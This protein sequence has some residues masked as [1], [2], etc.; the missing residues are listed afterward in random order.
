ML[1]RREVVKKR[2]YI[3]NL[4]CAHCAA[5]LESELKRLDGVLDVSVDFVGQVISLQY[6][7]DETLKKVVAHVNAFEEVRVL[8]DEKVKEE[9][10]QSHIKE[11][12]QL[13]LS[14]G[15][16][17]VGILLERLLLQNGWQYIAYVLY[18]AVYVTVGFPVL[19]NTA[20]NIAKG[21][22]FDENFLMT[23]ASIG[24]MALGEI[25]EGIAVMWLYQLG[26][27]LQ[28]IAVGSS[29]KSL[30][31]LVKLKSE[32]A[33]VLVDGKQKIVQPEQLQVGDTVL[34]KA[35]ERVPADG[36]LLSESA[37]I[38]T[39]ALTG[40]SDILQKQ[41][42]EEILSGCINAG[43]VYEMKVVRPY[44]DSAV[45][46]ILSLVEE[47]SSQ[48]AKPERFISK[49]A[50]YY[51]PIVCILAV[52]IA[53][54]VPVISRLALGVWSEGIFARWIQT[55][56]TFLVI[57]CPCALIISVPLTYFSGIGACAKYGVLVK[58]AVNLDVLAKTKI[59]AFDKTGTLTKGNFTV[60]EI[61]PCADLSKSQ[62]VLLA[63]A[64]EKGSSHSIAKAFDE[65]VPSYRAESVKELSGKGMCAQVKGE[66]VLVGNARLLRE[67]C[68]EF[69]E[70][71]SEDT[72]VYVAKGGKLVGVIEIGDVVRQESKQVIS[73]LKTLAI[74]RTVML[75]GDNEK[76]AQKVANEI[77]M[78]E[79][80]AKLLPDEKLEEAEYLKNLGVLTYVG[81]GINDAPVMAASDC[82]VS[83]G[84][85]GSAAAVEASDIVLISD[86]LR[87]IVTCLKVAKKTA[88][89]VKQNIIF[90]IAMKTAFMA[91]GVAGVLP[92][93]LAVFADV[94]VMLLA[95]CNSLRV[96]KI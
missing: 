95:V 93:A 33:T 2:I 94:G 36:V 56:L 72:L 90:S 34:V 47:A 69:D 68:V 3:E 32:Q 43:G 19:K 67:Y 37:Q 42:G 45:S 48:K 44:Q 96:R 82:A 38:D 24:A 80:K 58:G 1:I 50:K 54:L 35:G 71:E 92:L 63:A 17:L 46:K 53:V 10:S 78:Y 7:S 18:T 91:L 21:K 84:K 6:A 73:Q 66:Q 4:D 52:L 15:M 61:Y 85:L 89:I 23:V 27:L 81:D 14:L 12:L 26:E 39:K 25:Y 57:S 88:R 87:G 8:G 64:V 83:L 65:Y 74:E 86:D 29:R 62:L 9:G 13:A 55:A 31:E 60:K 76:K 49:F 40:E 28:A 79:F 11:I 51:T 16:F 5:T 77:G 59:V 20:K 41:K 22:V 30:V 75:T 70:W